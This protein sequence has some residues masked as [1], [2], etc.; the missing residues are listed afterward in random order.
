VEVGI[1]DVG[2][3]IWGMGVGM[4]SKLATVILLLRKSYSII[5]LCFLNIVYTLLNLHEAS[6]EAT[7]ALYSDPQPDCTMYN[8]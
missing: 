2:A 8:T 4:E 6:L 1:W 5:P 3:G 7:L